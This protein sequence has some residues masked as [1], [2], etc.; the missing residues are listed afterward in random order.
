MLIFFG[1]FFRLPQYFIR[2]EFMVF[3]HWAKFLSPFIK[4]RVSMHFLINPGANFGAPKAK[5]MAL[6][7]MFRGPET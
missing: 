3:G 2:A 4:Y 6:G 5:F 7:A 1:I